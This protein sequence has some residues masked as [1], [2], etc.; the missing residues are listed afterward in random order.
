MIRIGIL[1]EYVCCK[2]DYP[3]LQLSILLASMSALSFKVPTLSDLRVKV[4]EVFGFRPCL[5]QAKDALAQLKRK[6]VITIAPT[7]L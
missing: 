5:I 3:Y 1:T 4:E 2:R 7:G 6:D